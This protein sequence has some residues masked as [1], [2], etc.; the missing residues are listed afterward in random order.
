MFIVVQGIRGSRPRLDSPVSRPHDHADDCG[1]TAVLSAIDDAP[2][3]AADRARRQG[4]AEGS[5]EAAHARP[6]VWVVIPVRDRPSDLRDL[7]NDLRRLDAPARL[8]GVVVDN[9]SETPIDPERFDFP[10]WLETLRLESNRGGSGGFNAGLMRALRDRDDPPTHLWL[11]DSDARVRPDTLGALLRALEKSPDAVAVGPAIED[12]STIHEPTPAAR[13]RRVHELGGRVRR[14]NGQL[15][16][17][18]AGDAAARASDPIACD[19]LAACCALV[20]SNAARETGLLP[21]LF[22]NADDVAW[23][24]RLARE[25]GGRIL[26]DPRARA[27]HPRFDRYPTWAR[28]YQARNACAPLSALGLGAWVRFRRGLLETRRMVSQAVLGREDLA[29]L[30][31]LGLD[32]ALAGRTRGA[33]PEGR[34]AFEPWRPYSALPEALRGAGVTPTPALLREAERCA[35]MSRDHAPAGWLG[36]IGRLCAPRRE[37]A[38]CVPSVGGTACWFRG[39]VTVQCDPGGFVLR[40]VT[41]RGAVRSAS[42]YAWAGLARSVRLAWRP[43]VAPPPTP[44]PV[45]TDAG[46]AT[47]S[48]VV[49]SYNRRE[50]LERT[51]TNLS[52]T[53]RLAGA[54]VIV[55][56]NASTDGSVELVE[57]RFPEAELVRLSDNAGVEGFNAGADRAT[58]DLLLILDDDAWPEGESLDRAAG[59]LA[60]RPELAAVTLH[61]R[62][63]TTDA[64]E[65]PF[66]GEATDAWPVM[67]CGNLVRRD[68]WRRAGGYAGG[69]FLYR[70][71]TDLAMK[72]LALGRGVRFEPGLVVR[73]DSPQAV[74]KTPLWFF[75]A[76]RNWV[77]LARRHGRGWR[78]W[79]GALAGWVW[80][81]RLARLDW[82]GH[83]TVFRG[84]LTGCLVRPPMMPRGVRPDG[85]AFRR[86]LRMQFSTRARGR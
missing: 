39:R 18:L 23:F 51:L 78:R 28:Y 46:P 75:H 83:A 73:H 47:I 60:S 37:A 66:A 56:D 45:R 58:G 79:A 52:R 50:A 5:L 64:S 36:A 82:R 7:L 17:A 80:A 62:H 41:R 26:A 40:R 77:W 43:P 34:L 16:P 15:V 1:D 61:P 44:L 63:P 48:V 54:Q 2:T 25:T 57:S 19:Y 4:D 71:D 32:D 55:V 10:S 3:P 85:G 11:L 68:D 42:R 21:D 59:L 53:A 81:H 29:R 49:L 33:A 31:L 86:L 6:V 76:T 14:G 65:W 70:N 13:A 8:R 38:A 12:P 20:R 67:G 35:A 22:L 27:A 24:V 9:A 72:L 30:H 84:G 74:T 69:F